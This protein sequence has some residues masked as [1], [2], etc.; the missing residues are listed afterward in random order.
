[1]KCHEFFPGTT[2]T[3]CGTK[4]GL[5]NGDPVRDGMCGSCDRVAQAWPDRE[6]E[7]PRGGDLSSR[8]HE[9]P[10]H[11]PQDDEF[12][13]E[14]W[15][16]EDGTWAEVTALGHT[17]LLGPFACEDGAFWSLVEVQRMVS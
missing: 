4:L 10:E 8:T 7:A 11:E 5:Y 14:V 1:M 2:R 6:R 9:P 16:D 12:H 15:N 3:L 17:I 13:M